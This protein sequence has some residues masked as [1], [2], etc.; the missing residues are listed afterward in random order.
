LWNDIRQVI[1]PT[2][3]RQIGYIPIPRAEYSDD[4]IDLV[5]ENL[6]L[7]GPNLFPNII[8]LEAHNLFKFSPYDNINRTMDTQHHRFR[9]GLSQIQADIRDC[10]FAFRRKSGW[11]KFSDHGRG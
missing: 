9:L 5:I 10:A 8:E 11:P 4:K 6:I 3:I 7:S 2:M 1:L